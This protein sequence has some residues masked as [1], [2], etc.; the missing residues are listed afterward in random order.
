MKK[1]LLVLLFLLVG[2]HESDESIIKT[3]II[4]HHEIEYNNDTY[5]VGP[6]SYSECKEY[7]GKSL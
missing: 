5:V 6:I 4:H 3:E 7:K 1:L 2:C